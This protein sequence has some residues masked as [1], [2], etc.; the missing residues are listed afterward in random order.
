[1]RT[2]VVVEV[3]VLLAASLYA[4]S[5]DSKI[6]LLEDRFFKNST[7]LLNILFKH[8]EERIGL[9]TV[10][11]ESQ[12]RRALSDAVRRQLKRKDSSPE[13]LSFALNQC[14]DRLEKNLR[15]LQREPVKKEN[16]D[17][18]YT[19]VTQMYVNLRD[20]ATLTTGGIFERIA[21]DKVRGLPRYLKGVVRDIRKSQLRGK[22]TQLT[23]LL[24]HFPDWKDMMILAETAYLRSLY[25]KEAEVTMYL[26]STDCA[27]SPML[28]RDG[29]ISSQVADEIERLFQV[30]C[31]WPEKITE[32]LSKI[33]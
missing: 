5:R 21:T 26:A 27:F 6:L 2:K 12:A 28:N 17:P 14:G 30:R 20:R 7:E 13:A 4:T 19:R 8:V 9:I 22:F 16:V 23:R 3:S 32:E 15:Q 31:N 10:T 25:A 24:A 33:L 1:M 29:T 18:F 11:I